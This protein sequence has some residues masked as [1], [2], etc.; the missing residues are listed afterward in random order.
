MQKLKILLIDDTADMVSI[1]QRIFERAGYDFISARSAG[2]GLKK[3]MADQPACVILDFLLPDMQ[4]SQFIK[5]LAADPQYSAFR[6]LPV[7]VLTA[8]PNAS[9]ELED[10]FRLGLHACLYKPFGHRELVNV[11]ENISVN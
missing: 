11:V 10:C 2:E 1:G 3:I 7:I 4:G 6:D 5:I 9:K 8:H